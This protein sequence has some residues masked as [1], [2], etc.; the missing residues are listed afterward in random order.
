MN[1]KRFFAGLIISVFI[2]VPLCAQGYKGQGRITGVVT[3]QDGKPLPGVKVKLFSLKGQSGFETE[4][5][6]D[7]QW[8]ANYIRGGTW[9]LDFEKPGYMPKKL[10]AEVKEFGRNKPIEIR[11]EKMEGLVITD[12]LKAALS[13]GNTLYEA[14]RYEEAI[15]AYQAIVEANPDAYVIYKN[16]GNCY[17]Q[18]QKYEEA[19][20]YYQKILEKEPENADALLLIGNT[21]ANRGQDEKAMEWYDKIE[22]EK[23]TDPAVL[24]NLG[25]NFYKESKLD[26]AL[27]Y[28]RKA[29]E[30]NPDFLDA[31]Y[32]LGLTYLAMNNNPEAVASFEKYLKLDSC[33]ERAGQVKGFIEFLKKK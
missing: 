3:D 21:Y 16:I 2:S 26:Q 28:Y 27:K 4:T 8:K 6:Q 19:E 13:E 7:G 29:V 23:I 15:A 5:D 33:S 11:M 20:K 31:V 1:A 30:I 9:N 24:F 14:Q 18:L 25:A 22:F 12:E 10:S 17:F 32:Y